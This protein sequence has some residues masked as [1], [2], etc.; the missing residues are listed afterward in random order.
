MTG[1][2]YAAFA[3]IV[4]TLIGGVTARIR[5][6]R[7]Q[8]ELAGIGRWDRQARDADLPTSFAGAPFDAGHARLATDVLR[9]RHGGRRVLVFD[10]HYKVGSGSGGGVQRFWVAC[11]EDLPAPLPLLEVV[12][13]ARTGDRKAVPFASEFL[14]GDPEFDLRFHVATASPQL[15]ADVLGPEVVRLLVG[16]PDFPWRI[17]GHRLVTWGDGAVEPSWIDTTLNMLCALADAI[18]AQVWRNVNG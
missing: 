4:F 15:A 10:Y 6:D 18:P 3:G 7:A 1:L 9:G 13:R 16:W 5:R 17:E 2:G 11:V 14:H 8:R 12:G